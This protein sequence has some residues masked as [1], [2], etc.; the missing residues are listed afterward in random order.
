MKT[1]VGIIG[2]GNLGSALCRGLL[3]SS[4]A[5]EIL[6][7]DRDEERARVLVEEDER[8]RLADGIP[9][10]VA[11]S[12]FVFIAVKPQDLAP[13]LSEVSGVVGE[14]TAVIS[15]VA[16]VTL[17]RL[18]VGLGSKPVLFRMM[19]NL[20]VALG[21]GVV[22]LAAEGSA[23]RES[24]AA[25]QELLSGLG[26]VAFVSEEQ[27]NAVTA[28]AASGPGL[29]ALVLE[30][31]EDGGVSAG[32]SRSVARVFVQQMTLGTARM[33]LEAG[34][35]PSQ[36]KDRVASPGGTTIAGLAVLE[37]AG[38]RGALIRAVQAA[39]ARGREL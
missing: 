39:E 17:Q 38:V 21:E 33:L 13:V 2:T 12:D 36:L 25:V 34:E 28:V 30:A 35:S 19:P 26:S 14:K 7:F 6:L 3:G 27:F 20:A 1:T 4:A 8:A 9:A 22:A 37:E 11:G 16:G 32:L 15:S 31:L 24:V 29:L 10:L 18:R 23:R 5:S